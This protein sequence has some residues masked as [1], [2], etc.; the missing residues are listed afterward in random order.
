SLNARLLPLGETLAGLAWLSTEH[1]GGTPIGG[2]AFAP[3][4]LVAAIEGR[5]T[6]GT[7]A[8]ADGTP[9]LLVANRDSVA[10]RTLAL[11]LVGERHVE[12]LD[13]AGAGRPWP[14]PPTARG[15]RVELSLAAGDFAL[16]RL[17][18]ACGGLTAGACVATLDVAPNPATGRVRFA[19]TRVR[20]AATLVLLDVNGRRV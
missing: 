7:F 9:H 13:D 18:G 1:A 6:L 19:A 8:D 14:S 3:D 17:S 5:A 10:T 15:R 20:P 11:E 16:L 12:R 4:S 2:T